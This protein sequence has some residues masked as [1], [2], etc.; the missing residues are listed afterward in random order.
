MATDLEQLRAEVLAFDTD[1]LVKAVVRTQEEVAAL[2][3]NI[4]C[5]EP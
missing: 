2:L 4:R 5:M 3:R 1:A